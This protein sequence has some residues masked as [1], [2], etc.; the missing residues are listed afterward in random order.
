MKIVAL[1]LLALIAS[2]SFPAASQTTPVCPPEVLLSLARSGSA[3]LGLERGQACIGNGATH[4]TGFSGA[5]SDL[6][7]FEKPG[8]KREARLIA[9]VQAQPVD[10]GISTILLITRANLTEAEERGVFLFLFGEATLSNE[11]QPQT[12]LTGYARGALTI[13][14]TPAT[15]GD[16]M[17]RMAINQAVSANGR[18]KDGAWLRV[19]VPNTNDLGWVAAELVALQGDVVSLTVVGVAEP[20]LQPFQAIRLSSGET[21]YCGGMLASGLLVQT[22]NTFTSAEL[23]ING[24]AVRL[25]GTFFLQAGQSLLIHALDGW[26]EVTA[27]GTTEFVPAGAQVVVSLNAQ[28]VASGPPSQAEPYGVSRLAALPVNN[29]PTRIQVATPLSAE[30]IVR[31]REAFYAAVVEATPEPVAPSNNRACRRIVRRDTVL[32]GGPGEFYEA[33]NEVDAGTR[34]N[35]VYQTTDPDGEV[36]WQLDNSN[37]IPV[38]QVVQSGDCRRIPVQPVVQPPLVNTL[39]LETCKTSNGPLR[40]GQQ[41]T[42]EFIPQAFDNY[43]EARDALRIDPGSV[44]IEN[45]VYRASATDPIPVGSAGGERYIRRF[46]IVWQAEAGTYRIEGN[47]LHYRPTCTITVPVG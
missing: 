19:N 26:A 8:D 10:S 27:N 40:A 1:F 42:I 15:D 36:W 14:R 38:A 45:R 37:W 17:A 4:T 21:V 30:E 22:P 35:P 29:L 32:W 12:E 43:G 28:R 31:Q 24:A 18:T 33:V 7:P 16:I 3:C 6:A 34:V 9:S 39:S 23:T 41:V 46:Y 25:A 5:A 13:R 47:R 20:V 2:V 11:V 44:A